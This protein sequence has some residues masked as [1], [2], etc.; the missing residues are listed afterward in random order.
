MAI[1]TLGLALLA[2][3]LSVL[4]PCVLPLLPIVLG[5]AASEHRLGPLALAGGL[6]ISFTAIGLFVATVGFAMGLDT[7]VFRT[8]SAVLLIAVGVLLLVPRLQEQFAV[9]AGPVSQWAGGYLDNFAATGLVGQFGLGLLL[10]A[11]WSP[12]VGPTLGAA[13]LL[14]AKGENLG[15]VA[16]TML[17]FGIGAALPLMLLGFLSREAMQRWK[18]RMMEAGRGGKALLGVLL[19]AIGVLIASGLDKRLETAL[20]DASPDWLTTLTTRF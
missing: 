10:G 16:I 19:L 9:A 4:S 6:A 3:C 2:G 8:I 12:C 11:V 20:V 7:D 13:S 14:A 5:T 1:G 15:Q 18:G 17:A